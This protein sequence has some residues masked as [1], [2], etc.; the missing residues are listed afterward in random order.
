[1]SQK[2]EEPVESTP[3]PEDDAEGH[4]L[5]AAIAMSGI[6]SPRSSQQQWA[7]E[8]A[9]PLDPPSGRKHSSPDVRTSSKGKPQ[10]RS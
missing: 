4:M 8:D 7:K 3:E 6:L 5:G 1:M 10:S 9:L 2:P